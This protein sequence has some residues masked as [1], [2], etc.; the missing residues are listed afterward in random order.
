MAAELRSPRVLHAARRRTS[1]A[2]V[3]HP[4]AR[5][6]P[7][8]P[9]RRGEGA[10]EELPGDLQAA[11]RWNQIRDAERSIRT[12]DGRSG[13]SPDSG[14]FPRERRWRDERGQVLKAP[15]VQHLFGSSGCR[16]PRTPSRPR[17]LARAVEDQAAGLAEPHQPGQVLPG[18]LEI[19]E[20]DAQGD[21]LLPWRSGSGAR[22]CPEPEPGPR[23]RPAR[24]QRA[25]WASG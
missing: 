6:A 5:S 20:A 8:R 4:P 16:A 10:G 23:W 15:S 19:M 18:Q 12:H 13:R 22:S 7:R 14:R 25:R 21:A 2:G 9:E 24:R 11:C 17:S 3:A 1:R